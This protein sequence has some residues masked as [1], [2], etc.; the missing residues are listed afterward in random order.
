MGEKRGITRREVLRDGSVVTVAI[1]AAGPISGL[2]DIAV[3]VGS[4]GPVF[5]TPSE[6]E[7]LRALVDRFIP[8]KPEDSDDGALAAGCAEAIDALL[9]A[10]KVDPP[11][12]YAGSPFSDRAGSDVNHFER[13]QRLDRYERTAWRLRILGSRGRRELEFNGP[14][15]GWQ[16]IYREGLAAL[17]AAAAP[18]SFASLPGPARDLILRNSDDGAVAEL[19]DVAW[20]HTYE[21]MYGAPEYGGNQALIGWNYTNYDGDVQPRGWTRAEVEQPGSPARRDGSGPLDPAT[22]ERLAAIAPLAS[23]ELMHGIV[24]RSGGRLSGLRRELGPVI[25]A[26]ESGGVNGS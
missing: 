5:L 2:G 26:I 19:L 17:D 15:K 7:T 1:L 18:G 22:V 11:R 20:P 14:V 24:G 16:E 23:P 4:R 25:E 9:G 10:F 12:I 3:A 21:L 6:F 8:G 13:F